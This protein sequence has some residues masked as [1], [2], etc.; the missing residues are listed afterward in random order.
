MIKKIIALIFVSF[1]VMSG[2]AVFN[3]GNQ[4]YNI[5]QNNQ[6]NSFSSSS[7]KPYDFILNKSIT[8][9]KNIQVSGQT[10]GCYN[11]S[12]YYINSDSISKLN[13]N[14]NNI[15]TFLTFS[16]QPYSLEI[17]NNY[18]IIGYGNGVGNVASTLVNIY[19]FSN[20]QLYIF[21]LTYDYTGIQFSMI[22]NKMIIGITVRGGYGVDDELYLYSINL[23]PVSITLEKSTA[24][25]EN[26]NV[27]GMAGDNNNIIFTVISSA[28][29]VIQYGYYNI[30][31]QTLNT[32]SNACGTGASNIIDLGNY[33]L[34][35]Q[36]SYYIT[37]S[38]QAGITSYS[39]NNYA[40]DGLYF[41]DSNYK[42]HFIPINLTNN[43]WTKMPT[44]ANNSNYQEF[45]D[46][47][48]I[49]Y[50]YLPIGSANNIFNNLT[51]I[52]NGKNHL[53]IV[54]NN[55]VYVYP[56]I[57]PN[58]NLN[59]KSYNILNVQIEN[60]FL[61]NG[62]IYSGYSNN[63]IF[64]N[65]PQIN[66]IP[67]NT[68]L[69]YYNGSTIVVTQSDFSGNGINKYD[70]VSIYYSAPK[71]SSIPLYDIFT[72]MY[73]ISIIGLFVGMGAFVFVIKKR[74]Y[75]I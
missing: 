14:T 15:T 55:N 68:S 50:V 24:L 62:I 31:T 22:N 33:G 63:F 8:Y 74:G 56:N 23:F 61:L 6:I 2:L 48:N 4:N 7:F 43:E 32:S 49:S 66:I 42:N 20:K 36:E 57:I 1:F 54:N 12:L 59:V 30:L 67:L 53:F 28:P 52:I 73:P 34:C 9:S 60:Y 11:N 19:N 3:Q 26:T 39:K 27:M 5:V 16:N 58:Y 21:N 35:T 17:Y 64:T 71:S 38:N 41:A 29:T 46:N 70:N 37:D 13:V 69:Y 40:S 51:Y 72:Y 75:K 47:G 44:L 25:C 10:F 65:L 45:F 18:M